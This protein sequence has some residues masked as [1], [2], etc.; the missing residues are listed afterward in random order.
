[1]R[2][3][4]RVELSCNVLVIGGGLAAASAARS[5]AQF[6]DGVLVVSKGPFGRSGSTPRRATA[7][8]EQLVTRSEWVF[9]NP[10][11]IADLYLMDVV[12]AGHYLNDQHMVDLI[13]EACYDQLNWSEWFGFPVRTEA[14][15]NQR[16]QGGGHSSMGVF[17]R[18]LTPGHTVPRT[19]PFE[20]SPEGLV[21]SHREAIELWGGRIVEG[22][23]ITRLLT[24]DGR[25]VGATGF[26][27]ETGE[28]YRIRA[29][30]TVLCA[31]G[32]SV[33]YGERRDDGETTGDSYALAYAAGAP[34]ANME[35]VQ[36]NLYPASPDGR[37]A[38]HN[39]DLL[40]FAL[41]GTLVNGRGERFMQEAL[42]LVDQL[43]LERSPVAALVGEVHHQLARG[44][45]P[46]RSPGGE[47]DAG[48]PELRFLR[49]LAGLNGDGYDWRRDGFEWRLGVERLL[50]GLKVDYRMVS[51][52]PGLYGN[53]EAATGASGADCLP[54]YGV[55]YA[56]SCGQ[57]AGA[58]AARAA[59]TLKT[60]APLPTAQVEAAE[61]ALTARGGEAGAVAASELAALEAELR[62]LAWHDLGVWRNEDHLRAAR[63]RCDEIRRDLSRRAAGSVEDFR[64]KLELEHTALAGSLVAA[65]AMH[66]EE[67]RGQHR[68]EDY[69]NRDDRVW[70]KEVLLS[71]NAR[72][73]LAVQEQPV[74]LARY[75]SRHIGQVENAYSHFPR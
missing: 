13:T 20:G 33:L 4:D 21:D 27:V 2:Q 32:A 47:I 16:E 36:F 62:A 10:A 38:A 35:F 5:A 67:T 29:R 57:Q 60:E 48:T 63:T 49:S 17:P 11:V 50:G 3:P 65:A 46:V 72:E 68:R 64:R 31:G 75:K 14:A 23:M 9:G 52:L 12:E 8:S 61:A 70:L 71:R 69:P 59:V 42:L 44:L 55:V 30:S 53:G 73:G 1:M 22:V 54:G 34:L 25:V 41:G 51:P 43:R 7:I 45:G 39:D 37:V 26:D 66:R 40:Y 6:C 56:M 19:I 18:Y 24:A 28:P 58:M 74:A 15:R